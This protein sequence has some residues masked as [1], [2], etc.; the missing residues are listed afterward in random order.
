MISENEKELIADK[1]EWFGNKS[2]VDDINEIC[3][4]A[5]RDH[6]KIFGVSYTKKEEKNQ[7]YIRV[8]L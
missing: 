7:S 3:L 1:G 5:F 6:D 2:L 4:K 8:F